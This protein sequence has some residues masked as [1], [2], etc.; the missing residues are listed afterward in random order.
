MAAGNIVS[1]TKD[2]TNAYVSVSVNEGPGL[3]TV[4]YMAQTPLVGEDGTPKTAAKIKADLLAAVTAQ[5]PQG[6]G[7]TALPGVSGAVVV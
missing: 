4:E 5:R 6:S 3:G 2:G 7:K 1:A